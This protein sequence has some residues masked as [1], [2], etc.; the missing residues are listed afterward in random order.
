M[1]AIHEEREFNKKGVIAQL[2]NDQ[3]VGLRIRNKAGLSVTSVTVTTATDI[4][5]IDSAGTTAVDWATYTTMGAVADKIN[6]TTSWECK[7]LDVER[8]LTPVNALVT[9]V[10]S[11]AVVE[12]V[13]G[14][15]DAKLDTSAA[16]RYAY[17]LTPNR[18]VG[19]EAAKGK[20]VVAKKFNYALNVGTAAAASVLVIKRK[21]TVEETILSVASVDT[22]GTT[23]FDVSSAA[24]FAG[25]TADNDA[26]LLFVVKDAGSIADAG[27]LEVWGEVL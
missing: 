19:K 14:V 24:N 16:L 11:A 1:S 23:V 15:Y 3:S 18:A 5:L 26:E 20:K 12:G 4:T 9:G 27:L 6:S 17:C 13:G 25:L 7:L 8:S 2:T 21:G 22:T 10:V